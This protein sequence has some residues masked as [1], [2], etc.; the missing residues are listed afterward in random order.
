MPKLIEVSEE[1]EKEIARV[2][3]EVNRAYCASIGDHTQKAWNDAPGW[4]QESAIDGVRY[5]RKN[6]DAP[7]SD[8]H[9]NWMKTKRKEGWKYGPEKDEVKKEHPCF[10]PYNELPQEQR[11]K[12]FIFAAVVRALL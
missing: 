2:A 6:P 4:Q 5:H 10:V 7:L 9:E 12:D 1:M 11:S 8:S 3:H